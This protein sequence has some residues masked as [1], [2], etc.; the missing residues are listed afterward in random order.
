MARRGFLVTGHR[1]LS[2]VRDDFEHHP[3]EPFG[4][5]TDAALEVL[6]ATWGERFRIWHEGGMWHATRRDG[7]GSPL[8]CETP[9]E[10]ER[11]MRGYGGTS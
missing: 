5:D 3:R 4:V 10:L 11:A 9:D 2:V 1:G 8:S 6:N 7:E